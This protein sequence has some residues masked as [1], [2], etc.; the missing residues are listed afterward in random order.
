MRFIVKKVVNRNKPFLFLVACWQEAEV[1]R[2][3]R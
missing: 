3:K 2:I 1:R